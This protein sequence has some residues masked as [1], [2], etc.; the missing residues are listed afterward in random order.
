MTRRCPYCGISFKNSHGLY[1]HLTNHAYVQENWRRPL[2]GKHDAREITNIINRYREA[3]RPQQ[4]PRKQYLFAGG[5]PDQGSDKKA[6]FRFTDLPL[7]IRLMVYEFLFCYGKIKINYYLAGGVPKRHGIPLEFDSVGCSL[8]FRGGESITS[9]VHNPLAIMSASS[10]V[11][12]EARKVFYSQNKFF[13]PGLQSLHIFLLGIGYQNA[14]LLR[15]VECRSSK[16]DPGTTCSQIRKCAPWIK[17]AGDN[18]RPSTWYSEILDKLVTHSPNKG[19]VRNIVGSKYHALMRVGS[20]K[21]EKEND[22]FHQ[23]YQMKISFYRHNGQGQEVV[24]N[25]EV[26]FK[27][28]EDV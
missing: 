21:P 10:Q 17:M 20:H 22:I 12:T 19:R 9:S 28:F 27:V 14:Q 8:T 16:R 11:Y 1:T 6:T 7:E 5:L 23:L 13:F 3:E 4:A 18:P 24:T 25:G 15:T 2:D 26:S